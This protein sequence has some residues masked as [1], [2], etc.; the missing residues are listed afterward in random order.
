MSAQANISSNTQVQAPPL[1]VSNA[2]GAANATDVSPVSKT[3]GSQKN[4]RTHGSYYST[5]AALVVM[6]N[7]NSKDVNATLVHTDT[8]EKNGATYTA[9][10]NAMQKKA[11]ALPNVGGSG[12][13]NATALA[14]QGYLESLNIKSHSLNNNIENNASLESQSMTSAGNMEQANL[15]SAGDANAE[16][17]SLNQAYAAR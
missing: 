8:L 5:F 14:Q 12:S 7:A 13:S 1:S 4:P 2:G 3:G 10:L 17:K 15:A 6:M 9:Q 11:A 16:I